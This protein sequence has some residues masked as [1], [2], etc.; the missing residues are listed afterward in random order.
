MGLVATL[1]LNPDP[2]SVRESAAGNSLLRRL[3]GADTVGDL[4]TL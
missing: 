2:P 3:A 1:D 4:G